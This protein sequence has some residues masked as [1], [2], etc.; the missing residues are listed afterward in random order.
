MKGD[1]E[2]CLEAGMDDFLTK[3][4]TRDVLA[5][6]I[7]AAAQRRADMWQQPQQPRLDDEDFLDDLSFETSHQAAS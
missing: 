4:I 7:K 6:T 3:P 5:E 2:Q 1:R